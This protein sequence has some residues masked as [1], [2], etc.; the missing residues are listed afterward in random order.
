MFHFNDI[1][2]DLS[3]LRFITRFQEFFDATN[4]DAFLKTIY[5]EKQN[6]KNLCIDIIIWNSTNKILVVVTNLQT[7]LVFSV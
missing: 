5:L 2:L 7:P 3:H 6:V 1:I 4:T